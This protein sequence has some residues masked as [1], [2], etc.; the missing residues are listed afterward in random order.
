[1]EPTVI[2]NFLNIDECNRVIELINKNVYSFETLNSNRRMILFGYD[3]NYPNPQSDTSILNPIK[4][5]LQEAAIK[6][7]SL[8]KQNIDQYT[9]GLST[10]FFAK[11]TSLDSGMNAHIDA[12]DHD[13]FYNCSVV[14]YL[15]TT[16]GGEV[17]FPTQDVFYFPKMGD[18]ILFKSTTLHEPRK[19]N[20]DK[21]IIGMNLTDFDE[22]TFTL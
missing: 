14:I 15:N 12:E 10:I 19:T 2:S 18:L 13:E 5:I 7:L 8:A 17:F 1:M 3:T 22:F 11:Q 9:V 20:G 4:D 6:V 21:Y 16:D